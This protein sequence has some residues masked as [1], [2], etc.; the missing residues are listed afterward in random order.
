[1]PG[2]LPDTLCKE[3]FVCFKSTTDFRK[4]KSQKSHG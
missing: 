3:V 2:F 1:M 4:N